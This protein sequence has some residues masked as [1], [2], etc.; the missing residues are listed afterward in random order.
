MRNL[1]ACKY[2][3]KCG[4]HFDI[5]IEFRSINSF[6]SICF[7]ES[8]KIEVTTLA[9]LKIS[10]IGH[11]HTQRMKASKRNGMQNKFNYY[12][13]VWPVGTCWRFCSPQCITPTKP[14]NIVARDQKNRWCSIR[15][16]RT[17]FFVFFLVNSG[18]YIFFCKWDFAAIQPANSLF[19]DCVVSEFE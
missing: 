8:V 18:L 17:N 7:Q 15:S 1:Y 11:L 6:E 3:S 9:V 10:L 4:R 14:I 13:L 19:S 5:K 2:S 12:L 16:S